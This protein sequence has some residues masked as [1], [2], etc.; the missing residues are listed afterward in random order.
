MEIDDN[1]ISNDLFPSKVD[2]TKRAAMDTVPTLDERRSSNGTSQ[3]RG[4]VELF[5]EKVSR[6]GTM[7]LFPEKVSRT[8]TVELFPEKVSAKSLLERIQDDEGGR[9][10]L[11]PEKVGGAGRRNRRKAEDHF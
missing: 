1:I 4:P 3:G 10:E 11:F 7:E 8:G 2:T 6:T 5:P 9:R